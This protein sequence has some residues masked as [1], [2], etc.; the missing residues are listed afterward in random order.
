MSTQW[1]QSWRQTYLHNC[2]FLSYLWK[3]WKWFAT[4]MLLSFQGKSH[5]IVFILVMLLWVYIHTRQAWKICLTTVGNEPT[6]FDLPTVV[7]R[8]FQACPVWIYTQS[9][10]TSIIFTWVHYTNTEKSCTFYN[11]H[12]YG[13]IN[14]LLIFD[15]PPHPWQASRGN[16]SKFFLTYKNTDCSRHLLSPSDIF[17][18][19]D[20]LGGGGCYAPTPPTGYAPDHSLS[21]IQWLWAN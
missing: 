8:I 15:N 2:W 6:T 21:E 13:A 7:R 10:I 16:I 18:I 11:I 12:N 20:E 14:F 17:Q 1:S 4:E 9:N 3:M 5:F 19:H